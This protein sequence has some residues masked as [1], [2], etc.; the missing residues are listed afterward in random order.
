MTNAPRWMCNLVNGRKYY[1]EQMIVCAFMRR[2]RSLRRRTRIAHLLRIDI[3]DE[4]DQQN[5]AADQNLQETID[6]DV[7]EPVVEHP[8]TNRPMMVLPMPPRPPNRLVPP[9]TTAAIES[10]KNVSNWFCWAL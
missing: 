8:S 3:D 5:E 1:R 10:S 9:T 2:A 4:R 6:I 7:I